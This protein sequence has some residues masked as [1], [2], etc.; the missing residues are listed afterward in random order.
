MTGRFRHARNRLES[1]AGARHPLVGVRRIHHN[2]AH[3]QPTP[4]VF[5]RLLRVWVHRRLRLHLKQEH[6]DTQLKPTPGTLRG[7]NRRSCLCPHRRSWLRRSLLAVWMVAAE[8]PLRF[9]RHAKEPQRS[10]TLPV[11]TIQATQRHPAM[12]RSASHLAAAVARLSTR[13]IRGLLLHSLDLDLCVDDITHARSGLT[14]SAALCVEAAFR[15]RAGACAP[16]LKR[17]RG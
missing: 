17:G 12:L 14:V 2:R 11:G 7:R 16:A 10:Q 9:E 1:C 6:A 8:E 5:A 4:L 13:S 3:L 15:R